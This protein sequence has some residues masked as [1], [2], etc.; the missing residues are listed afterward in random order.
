MVDIYILI[1]ILV[2]YNTAKNY[3]NIYLIYEYNSILV[4]IKFVVGIFRE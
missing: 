1:Q 3:M 2:I 4:K